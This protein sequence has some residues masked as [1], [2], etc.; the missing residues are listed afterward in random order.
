[1][2]FAVCM[3]HNSWRNDSLRVTCSCHD[4]AIWAEIRQADNLTAKFDKHTDLTEM[5]Y[6]LLVG[7]WDT[8]PKNTCTTTW[9]NV[10]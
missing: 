8:F 5:K 6:I 4:E 1:M 9:K 10:T 7:I 2:V 3:K